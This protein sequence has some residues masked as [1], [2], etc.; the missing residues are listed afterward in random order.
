MLADRYRHCMNREKFESDNKRM[1]LRMA[2]LLM[3]TDAPVV[4]GGGR[5]PAD[6]SG[7]NG[8]VGGELPISDTLVNRI[9]I[10]LEDRVKLPWLGQFWKM[11]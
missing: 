8:V 7:H 1:I 10:Q 4:R 11:P 2:Q 6:Q 9:G 3:S 5:T